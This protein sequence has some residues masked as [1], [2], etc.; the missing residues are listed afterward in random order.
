MF[1]SNV[2][3]VLIPRGKKLLILSGPGENSPTAMKRGQDLF[4]FH[5][6]LANFLGRAD[7]GFG[8]FDGFS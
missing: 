4:P 7:F 2:G 1:C 8:K 3:K 5:S 6:V